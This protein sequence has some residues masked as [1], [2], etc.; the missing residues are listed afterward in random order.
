M[1]PMA[2]VRLRAALNLVNYLKGEKDYVQ[3][4]SF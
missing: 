1:A 2:T 3:A 4:N